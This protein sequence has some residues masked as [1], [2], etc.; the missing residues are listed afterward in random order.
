MVI[1]AGIL[2]RDDMTQPEYCISEKEPLHHQHISS[3]K[4]I[5]RVWFSNHNIHGLIGA[6][7]A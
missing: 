2:H 7:V 3:I 6:V 4:L 1:F 5:C